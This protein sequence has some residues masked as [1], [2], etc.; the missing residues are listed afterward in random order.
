VD[1]KLLDTLFQVEGE[2]NVARL[3]KGLEPTYTILA[4]DSLGCYPLFEEHVVDI[5][6]D[7]GVQAALTAVFTTWIANRP[8]D[9]SKSLPVT[10]LGKLCYLEALRAIQMVSIQNQV[11]F[12]F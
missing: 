9:D 8:E 6:G 7:A 4:R 2:I 1:P 11:T 5:L 12:L 10:I 3:K